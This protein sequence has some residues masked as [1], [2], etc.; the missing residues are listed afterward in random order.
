MRD[1]EGRICPIHLNFSPF[2]CNSLQ[3][4]DKRSLC[5]SHSFQKLLGREGMIR[6][7]G[8]QQRGERK[9]EKEEKK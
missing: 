5:S 2:K 9:I 3:T 8:M 4:D 7:V 6:G 1:K